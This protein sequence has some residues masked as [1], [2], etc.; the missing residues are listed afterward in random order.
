V[1]D[2][3]AGP[4]LDVRALPNPSLSRSVHV[5]AVESS[6][7]TVEASQLRVELAGAKPPTF[8]AIAVEPET[9]PSLA[10]T[11]WSVGACVFT[12]KVTL[13]TPAPFVVLVA[14]EKEPPFVLDH[15]TVRPATAT[16]LLLASS[17]WAEIV[18]AEP[19]CGAY[20]L[21]LTENFAAPPATNDTLAFPVVIV[22][23]LSVAPIVALPSVA[24][25]VSVAM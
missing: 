22:A 21:E 19:A 9:E 10:V 16:G 13:A 20:E 1:V 18:T 11:T 23:P 12:V 4:R 8:V 24:G 14:A 15:V 7:V 25:A 17:S 3:V 5:D 6:A 2:I